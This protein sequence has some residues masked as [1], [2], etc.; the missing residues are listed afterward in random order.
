VG[1]TKAAAL[2]YR[3]FESESPWVSAF[4]PGSKKRRAH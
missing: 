4:R 3:F 2:P 1:I